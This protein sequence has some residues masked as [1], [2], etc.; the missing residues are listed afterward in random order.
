MIFL[1]MSSAYLLP[2]STVVII[3]APIRRIS[4]RA[5]LCEVILARPH[6]RK[7]SITRR[8]LFLIFQL[9][10]NE[11]SRRIHGAQG[12]RLHRDAYSPRAQS[13]CPEAWEWQWREEHGWH[14][15]PSV[16]V[17]HCTHALQRKGQSQRDGLAEM[18]CV[19][20]SDGASG[21]NICVLRW[22]S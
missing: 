13:A 1:K 17:V 20:D 7:R 8:P 3:V 12:G 10:Q 9:L 6:R 2:F 21:P 11:V 5:I 22:Q 4:N 15:V 16:S 19:E 18:F 14:K